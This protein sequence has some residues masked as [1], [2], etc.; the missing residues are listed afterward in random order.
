MNITN[1]AADDRMP[2]WS[3][4]G[5]KIAF[6]TGQAQGPEIVNR[7]IYLMNPD[8][9][10]QVKISTG[11]GD[12]EPAWQSLPRLVSKD[13]CKKGG[14]RNFI[15]P[16]TGRPFKNQGQCVSFVEHQTH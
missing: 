11:A 12:D 6:T 8:G 10:N 13:Q 9:S 4:D 1:D 7:G 16:R 2:A 15:D 14:Y 3:P 5:T